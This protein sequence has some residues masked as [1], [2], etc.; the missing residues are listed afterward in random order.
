MIQFISGTLIG[1]AVT[2]MAIV[3][4]IGSDGGDE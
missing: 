4:F 3:F 1:G 2:F